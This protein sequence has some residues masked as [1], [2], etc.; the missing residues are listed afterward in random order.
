MSRDSARGRRRPHLLVAAAVCVVLLLVAA[1]LV[2][3]Y[4]VQPFRVQY[5]FGTIQQEGID[6][7]LKNTGYFY[8]DI[9][10]RKS[11]IVFVCCYG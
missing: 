3:H 6:R 5:L 9:V 7:Y 1:M 10:R 2:R 11:G 8:E 4:V